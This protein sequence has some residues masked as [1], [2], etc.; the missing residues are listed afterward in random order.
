MKCYTNC[1]LTTLLSLYQFTFQNQVRHSERSLESPLIPTAALQVFKKYIKV[2]WHVTHSK[3]VKC[4]H[5]STFKIE[6]WSKRC[7]FQKKKK[8]KNSML[9]PHFLRSQ[10]CSGRKLFI[11]SQLRRITPRPLLFDIYRM[12]FIIGTDLEINGSFSER[13]LQPPQVQ[14]TKALTLSSSPS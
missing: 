10:M 9:N 12:H 1:R 14:L 11:I 13:Q 8:K 6:R 3:P 2:K 5:G 7:L 4:Q